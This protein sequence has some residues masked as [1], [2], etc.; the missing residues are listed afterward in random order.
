M[1][2]KIPRLVPT[3]RWRGD[4]SADGERGTCRPAA[5]KDA[6]YDR[7]R[8][9]ENVPSDTTDLAM[10]FCASVRLVRFISAS[11]PPHSPR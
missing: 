3:R 1:P 7:G 4:P 11:T 2:S 8:R 6:G 9:V 10:T 5:I